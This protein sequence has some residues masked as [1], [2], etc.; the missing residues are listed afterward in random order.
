MRNIKFVFDK[1]IIL[2]VCIMI[3]F[4]LCFF[5]SFFTMLGESSYVSFMFTLTF[6]V[7]ILTF[8]YVL[9]KEKLEIIDAQ[10]LLILLTIIVFGIISILIVSKVIS[11]NYLKNT[12]CFYLL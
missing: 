12:L 3:E 11:F 6:I 9:F 8:F 4:I 1:D 7:L 5:I 10:N 2:N